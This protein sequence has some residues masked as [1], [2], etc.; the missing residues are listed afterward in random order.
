[1]IGEAKPGFGAAADRHGAFNVPAN[2][3]FMAL[4]GQ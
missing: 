4:E 2:L 3:S 1:M